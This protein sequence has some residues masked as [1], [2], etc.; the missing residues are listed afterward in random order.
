MG[1]RAPEFFL[2]FG[3]GGEAFVGPFP[4]AA[5]MVAALGLYRWKLGGGDGCEERGDMRLLISIGQPVCVAR[6]LSAARSAIS[7][8]IIDFVTEKSTLFQMLTCHP[9]YLSSQI[10]ARPPLEGSGDRRLPYN[11][12]CT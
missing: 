10:S 1:E 4:A 9:A 3:V 2:E 11:F 7:T 8:L 6:M 12:R 5:E